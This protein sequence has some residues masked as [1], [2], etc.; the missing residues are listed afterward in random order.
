MYRGLTTNWRKELQKRSL[1]A[2][3]DAAKVSFLFPVRAGGG[4]QPGSN[5]WVLGGSRTATGRPILANDPHL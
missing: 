5:A 2:G 4:V 1:L 3:G